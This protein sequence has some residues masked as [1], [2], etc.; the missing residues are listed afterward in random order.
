MHKL[1]WIFLLNIHFGFTQD[2]NVGINSGINFSDD[3]IS[4]RLGSNHTKAVG[5]GGLTA[6]IE[7]KN[8]LQFETGISLLQFGYKTDLNMVTFDNAKNYPYDFKGNYATI[9]L[10]FGLHSRGDFSAYINTGAITGILLKATGYY[11][12]PD[13][14]N[15]PSTKFESANLY[16][17]NITKLI[18][19][20]LI[21]IGFSFRIKDIYQLTS[22]YMYTFQLNSL[23]NEYFMPGETIKLRGSMLTIGLKRK[24]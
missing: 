1:V 17:T 24:I 10:K 9:P 5:F 18:I 13:P 6:E 21:E 20:G 15:Y 23:T 3:Q 14:S 4:N 8:S 22:S 16:E 12:N 2:F 19:S 11:L 7:L